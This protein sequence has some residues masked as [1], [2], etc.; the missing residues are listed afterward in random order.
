MSLRALL[1]GLPVPIVQAPMVGASLDRLA[2]AVSAAGGMGT[3]AAGA[4]APD[5]IATA[6]GA[7]KAASD[8][9]F[10]VNLLMAPRAS[11]DAA[12][13]A[14]ALERL[15]PWYAEL[16]EP[17]PDA[18]N[19]YAPDFEAQLAAI[20]AA[21]PPVASFTFGILAR[22]QVTAL[23][24]AGTCVVGTATSVAE[25]RAWAEVGADGVCAQGFE[26]GG[27]RGHFLAE[28]DASLVGT[29]ALVATIRAAVDLPV[30]A[31]GGIMDGRGVAAALALGASAAQMGTAFL[32]AEEATTSKPWRRALSEAGDEATRLT[33]AFTGRY[34]RGVENRFMRLMHG[35][36][37][38]VPAYPVQNR[39]T[40]PLRAAAAKSDDPEMLSLW[41]G[42][43][44]SLAR[45][46]AAGDMVRR[47][48]AEARDAA[49]ELA[50][51]TGR[52]E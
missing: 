29:M 22:D 4:L 46:G 23:R 48:W 26:A 11:P 16:G 32:L 12:I 14:A 35:V 30:I 1:D 33:R 42:Q 15:A 50:A 20:V 18:P 17:L 9:P 41:A 10:G 36:Q 49:C 6:I 19:Q 7:M 38:D 51:R 8:R 34:A 45:P 3:L 43:A 24:A 40:Q 52:P 28:L 47:W 39:L 27:H 25:A 5:D 44:V 21:A 13:V 2:L 37:A 31:A